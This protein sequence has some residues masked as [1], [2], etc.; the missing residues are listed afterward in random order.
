MAT[1]KPKIQKQTLTT[2]VIVPDT[3]TLWNEDKS[4]VVNPNFEKF[5]DSHKMTLPMELVI[6]EVVVGELGYQQTASANKHLA[7]LKSSLEDISAIAN[8]RHDTKINEQLLK[9]QISSKIDKWLKNYS[10]KIRP[11]PV[12]EIDWKQL[13]SD[14]IWRKAP[15]SIDSEKGFRDALI[16]QTLISIAKDA[17]KANKNTVFISKDR[18]LLNSAKEYFGDDRNILCF[19]TL[20]EFESYIRL[21][22]EKLTNEF[23][24][25]IQNRAGTRFFHSDDKTC[26]YRKANIP[27]QVRHLFQSELEPDAVNT[28]RL[29]G[30]LSIGKTRLEKKSSMRWI[31]STSFEK[32]QHPRLYFWSTK[33]TFAYRFDEFLDTSINISNQ[34]QNSWILLF[35]VFVKWSATVK[36]DGRFHDLKSVD[37][38]AGERTFKLATP[39]LLERWGLNENLE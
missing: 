9:D 24:T 16:L 28:N 22:Q 13:I 21:T 5:L 15:F 11:A 12:D 36:T 2:H 23:V 39:D 20:K 3:N 1:R 34:T 37:I 17:S 25:G 18:L 4:V 7:K 10:A 6:S 19:E 14:A 35:E 29:A 8:K 30:L 26:L 27:D 31:G 38:V 33:I 32:I